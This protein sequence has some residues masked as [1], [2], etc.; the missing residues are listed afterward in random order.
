MLKKILA[1][2]GVTVPIHI[3]DVPDIPSLRTISTPLESI[4]TSL[5]IY[6]HLHR[7]VLPQKKT[8]NR[9]DFLS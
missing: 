6:E 4:E 2:V 5:P 7:H 3:T 1:P 9:T 8:E